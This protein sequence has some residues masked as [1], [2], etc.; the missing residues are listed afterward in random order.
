MTHFQ[1]NYCDYH[2]TNQDYDKINRPNGSGDFLF[3]HFMTPMK[4]Y[5]GKEMEI[6]RE[7]AFLLFQP[8]KPQIYQ[9]VRRFTNSFIHFNFSGTDF[10]SQY[11]IPSSRIIYPGNPE[12]LSKLFQ[13]INTEYLEKQVFHEEL[14]SHLMSQL[15]FLFSR[16][17]H[18]TLTLPS[19]DSD[20]QELFRKARIEILTHTE[21]DWTTETMAALTNMSVSQFYHYYRLF[22]QQSPKNELI[23][24]RINRAKYLLRQENVSVNQTALLTGFHSLSHFSR[25]FQKTCGVSASEYRAERRRNDSN[26][27]YQDKE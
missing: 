15:F 10:C 6:A 26:R 17:M 8:G 22:F 24:A 5:I 23:N 25:L 12:E 9:A 19:M 20:L 11:Q 14:I 4:V 1:V 16:Q 2:H 27:R 21:K 18:Q 13:Q 7:G 3:L